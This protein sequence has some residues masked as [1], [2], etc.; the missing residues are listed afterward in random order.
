M[1][2]TYVFYASADSLGSN[3][4]GPPFGHTRFAFSDRTA[5]KMKE[6]DRDAI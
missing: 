6:A 4:A 3:R 5:D 2:I 1:Q